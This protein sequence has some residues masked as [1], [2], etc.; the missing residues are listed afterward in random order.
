MGKMRK[1]LLGGIAVPWQPI[2]MQNDDIIFRKRGL[3]TSQFLGINTRVSLATLRRLPTSEEETSN[4]Q[5][6]CKTFDIT[7]TGAGDA[8]YPPLPDIVKERSNKM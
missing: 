1:S 8:K 3:M 6:G 2:R 7:G 5:T 4:E